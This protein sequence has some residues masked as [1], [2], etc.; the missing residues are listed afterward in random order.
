MKKITDIN[1]M[2]E[3]VYQLK[4][5]DQPRA[6]N[7][8]AINHEFNGGA[9]YTQQE[10]TENG[11]FTNVQPLMAP[12]LAHDA[13]R[14][15]ERSRSASGNYFTVHIDYGP[16]EEQTE[17]SKTVT[18]AINSDFKNDIRFI[19]FE[20][21]IDANVVLHGRG[22][23]IWNDDQDPTSTLLGIEDFKVPADTFTDFSNLTHFACYMPLSAAE[24]MDKVNR[25]R[26]NPGWNVPYVKRVIGALTEEV[27]ES[28]EADEDFPEKLAEDLKQN[29]GY[30][31]SDRVPTAKCWAFFQLVEDKKSKHWEMSIFEDPTESVAGV[32]DP[33]KEIRSSKAEFLFQQKTGFVDDIHK[34]LHCQ[35]AD[36]SNVPPFRYHSVRGLGYLLYPVM[37]LFDRYFCRSMDSYFEAC[38]QLFRNVGEEDRERLQHVQLANFS[39]IPVGVEYVTANERY[40]VN[41]NVMN[42]A[43]AMLRQFI[44]ENSA[45][46]TQDQDSGTSK[47]MTA[48][49]AMAR[50][51]QATALVGSMLSMQGIYRQFYFRECCRRYCLP[52]NRSDK[53]RKFRDKM[54]E[55]GV[56]DEA[57]DFDRWNVIVENA[58]GS[59][60]KVLELSQ[61]GEMMA[62]RAAFPPQAQ[63]IILKDYALARYDNPEKVDAMLP[64]EPPT[65]SKTAIFANL[66]M[67]TLLQGLPVIVQEGINL[68]E[69][70]GIIMSLL[71]QRVQ[72][73][74]QTGSPP[75]METLLGL[76]NTVTHAGAVIE[77]LAQDPTKENA[78]RG[79]M[80]AL[81]EIEQQVQQW[82]GE[83]Q[84]QQGQAQLTPE[85][86]SKI[87]SS[88]V[89]AEN[90][91]KIKE[92][93]AMQKMQQREQ[94]H[95]QKMAQGQV[96]LQ[97]DLEEKDLRTAND[98]RSMTMKNLAQARSTEAQAKAKAQQTTD[99]E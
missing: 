51:Q 85:A 28:S 50:V 46:F 38:N 39:V 34:L 88:R 70:A 54:R 64:E 59:G 83:V 63:Q 2:R 10:A 84:S 56:P 55:K 74:A 80:Q 65:P 35:F 48:T 71:Q 27:L 20:R 16:A 47:E 82:F 6:K 23:S 61:T 3:I 36:G 5:D 18:R 9:P 25:K 86:Q 76:Q 94:S 62:A 22:P 49:E 95:Q 73:I 78:M 17:L 21:G 7:R 31:A 24:L 58:I 67:G 52:N 30:Y 19:E 4:T 87:I 92:A 11:I 29:L 75:A 98:L 69:Y 57:F 91:A 15:L 66:A 42:A 37:R 44:S 12:R 8:A 99:T 43:L 68:D 13:R 45:S 77:Q 40:T 79:A 72:Q 97:A 32:L 96:E 1:P 53:V 26:V 93:Q 89:L 14:Q 90:Q 41:H 81:G 33:Y 60:N